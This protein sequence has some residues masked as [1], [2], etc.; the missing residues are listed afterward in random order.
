MFKRS[1]RK[2]IVSIAMALGLVAAA[3][4][5][6]AQKTG[7]G[8]EA[9]ILGLDEWIIRFDPNT[10]V[11]TSQQFDLQITNS[12]ASGCS[13]RLRA[14]SLASDPYLL[15]VVGTGRVRYQLTDVGNGNDITPNPADPLHGAAIA[16]PKNGARPAPVRFSIDP[17]TTVAAGRYT[18]Q[19]MIEYVSANGREV[20]ATKPVTLILDVRSSILIG[21]TGRFT[22]ENSVPTIDLGEL[23]QSS[24]DPG[25]QVYVRSSGPYRMT[26]SSR[27]GGELRHDL[28]GWKINY[29]MR[30]GSQVIDLTRDHQI[31]VP[32][33]KVHADDYP[34]VFSI[35][36]TSGRR[37]GRYSDIISF[38]VSAI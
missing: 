35:G 25:V 17:G 37:A 19:V 13:G 21:L 5:A 34:L 14:T 29:G 30:M 32:Q 38:T 16:V 11:N 9:D 28:P 22:R 26:V 7:G 18:Q 12:G 1:Y 4:Q 23:T 24:R 10:G 8:C 27:N 15:P 31:V 2:L 33:M 6:Q 20:M 36:D 3:G